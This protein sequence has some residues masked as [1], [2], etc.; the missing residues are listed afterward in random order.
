MS[1][2]DLLRM[3]EDLR[4]RLA[5]VELQPHAN[6]WVYLAA[7]LTSTS[8]DGDAYS[9]TA[10]TLIDLSTVFSVPAG[11][12]A[13]LVRL[14][15]RDSASATTAGV[16]AALSPNNT[17]DSLALA[18]SPRGLVNDYYAEQDSICP[19]DANGDVYFQCVASGAATLDVVIQIWGYAR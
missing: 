19:C 10:K 8:W 4:R 5:V 17:A 18:V 14:S 2:V 3:I 13:V 12:K 16:Y 1:E 9:T 15:A 7:P 11:V 6:N